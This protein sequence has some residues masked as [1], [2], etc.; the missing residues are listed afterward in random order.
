MSQLK[1][2]AYPLLLAAI[3]ALAATGGAFRI[4]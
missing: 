1:C 4:T 2:R 3:T